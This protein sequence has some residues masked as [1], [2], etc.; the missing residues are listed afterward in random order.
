[1]RK[2]LIV[3]LIALFPTLVSAETTN[4]TTI[5]YITDLKVM[6]SAIEEAPTLALLKRRG[7][8]TE[9]GG[10][11]ALY[12]MECV[13]FIYKDRTEANGISLYTY[14]DG[15]TK[16]LKWE[17]TGKDENG[18]G[19]SEGKGTGSYISG[20]GRFEGLKGTV[21]FEAKYLT[22]YAPDKGTLGDAVMTVVSNYTVGQ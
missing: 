22:S 2:W 11:K 4:Y 15:S 18:D 13:A 3:A 1:M 16:V 12:Q 20:S 7:V 14:D 6:P 9:E 19:L 17:Y 21:E 10:E 5:S 8:S